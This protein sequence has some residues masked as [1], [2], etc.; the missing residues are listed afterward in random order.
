V[1]HL[2]VDVEGDPLGDIKSFLTAVNGGN[3]PCGDCGAASFRLA[4]NLISDYR[5]QLTQVVRD[6]ESRTLDDDLCNRIRQGETTL[7]LEIGRS[8]LLLF[9]ARDLCLCK[10]CG[11]FFLVQRMKKGRP[12]RDYCTEEHRR[13]L[14]AF[15]APA[16][17]KKSRRDRA[18]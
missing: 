6:P 9:L 7:E 13:E 10:T 3:V 18:H 17:A 2:H 1:Q 11:D 5:E 15:R 4:A 16:R 12:R 14:Y 8:V